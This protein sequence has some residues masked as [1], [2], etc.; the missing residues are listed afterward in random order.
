M[1]DKP[2]EPLKASAEGA[3]TLWRP[4]PAPTKNQDERPFDVPTLFLQP[5]SVKRV[6]YVVA[7]CYGVSVPDMRSRRRGRYHLARIVAL[8]LCDKHTNASSR[9]LAK[10][11]DRGE[12]DFIPRSKRE[13]ANRRKNDSRIGAQIKAIEAILKGE[14]SSAALCADEE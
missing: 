5:T 4:Q 6:Q 2:T 14:T 3:E 10:A 1:L 7:R 13:I 9:D 11:F 8:W 12:R